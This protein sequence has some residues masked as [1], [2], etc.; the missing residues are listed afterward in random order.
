MLIDWSELTSM[1]LMLCWIGQSWA[2]MMVKRTDLI[3]KKTE[4]VKNM[5][6]LVMMADRRECA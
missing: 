2:S 4:L 3:M 6:D 1:V 5:M